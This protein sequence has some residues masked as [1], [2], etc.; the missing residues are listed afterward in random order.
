M[1][2]IQIGGLYVHFKDPTKRYVVLGV[3]KHSADDADTVVYWALYPNPLSRLWFR[4]PPEFL[5]YVER[6]GYTGPRFRFV[7]FPWWKC[8]IRLGYWLLT[9]LGA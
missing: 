9:K 4:P 7:G 6:D 1:N 3:G 5:G 8:V 2:K